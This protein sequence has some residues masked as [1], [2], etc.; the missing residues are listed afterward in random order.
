MFF[1][2]FESL[3]H[4]LEMGCGKVLRINIVDTQ[5]VM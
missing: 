1:F 3:V 2:F 5:E 4:V